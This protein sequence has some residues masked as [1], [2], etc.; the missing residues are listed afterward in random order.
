MFYFTF[1]IMH[2][3]HTKGIIWHDIHASLSVLNENDIVLSEIV[4]NTLEW[5]KV[6]QLSSLHYTT[7]PLSHD[8]Y[9]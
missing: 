5:A 4:N 1:N 6:L 7:I 3:A 9:Q 8:T 2:C